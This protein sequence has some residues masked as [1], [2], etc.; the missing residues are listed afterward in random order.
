MLPKNSPL[1]N[2][3]TKKQALHDLDLMEFDLFGEDGFICGVYSKKENRLCVHAV[4]SEKKGGLKAMMH[5]LCQHFK[6]GKVTF[7]QILNENLMKVLKGFKPERIYNELIGEY[8]WNLV[9]EWDYG[10]GS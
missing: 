9:G 1:W 4:N 5:K 8:Q 7:T 3:V 6:T 10:Q 2:V